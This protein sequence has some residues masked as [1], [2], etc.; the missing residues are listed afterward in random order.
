[1]A[2]R[3]KNTVI[4]FAVASLV[5]GLL[6]TVM[7]SAALIT[8]QTVHTSGILASANLGVYADSACTQSLGSVNWGTISPG[9]SVSR[10]IYVKNLGSSQVVLSLTKTNWNPT[11]ANGPVAVNWNRAGAT[12]AAKQVLSATLT[13]SVSTTASGFT[14]FSVD[15]VITG[16]G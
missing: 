13:L 3:G 6:V 8:S 12:L 4:V 16:T 11:T 9:S 10:T 7:A 1:M 5:A 2:S 15:A 14:S